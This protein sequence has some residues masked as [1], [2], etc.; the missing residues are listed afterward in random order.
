M[1]ERNRD[2]RL[3]T[4]GLRHIGTDVGSAEM[5]GLI[6]LDDDLESARPS[7]IDREKVPNF[8]LCKETIIRRMF[9]DTGFFGDISKFEVPDNL[10]KQL[11]EV[12]TEKSA[13]KRQ[14]NKNIQTVSNFVHENILKK[15]DEY[16]SEKGYRPFPKKG[17]AVA[18]EEKTFDFRVYIG[19]MQLSLGFS[20]VLDYDH[21]FGYDCKGISMIYIDQ[22]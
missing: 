8:D 16:N 21:R 6:G 2:P 15:L 1:P 10:I 17:S 18:E 5:E 20:M 13:R 19:E 4:S 12:K 14:N 7:N 22:Y 11:A 3:Y 9:N